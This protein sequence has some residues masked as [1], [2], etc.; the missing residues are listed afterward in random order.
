M[1]DH[2]VD[3]QALMLKDP[4]EKVFWSH[5]LEGDMEAQEMESSLNLA[6]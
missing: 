2:T 4:L 1:V 6:Q 3:S 5:Q